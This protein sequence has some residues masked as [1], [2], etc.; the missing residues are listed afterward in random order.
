MLCLHVV[1]A[2]LALPLDLGRWDHAAALLCYANVTRRSSGSFFT[3]LR[4]ADQRHDLAGLVCL[5]GK[6]TYL[7]CF[8]IA[9]RYF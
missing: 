1:L 2:W 9:S 3:S 7:A 5:L 8:L 4:K 6:E